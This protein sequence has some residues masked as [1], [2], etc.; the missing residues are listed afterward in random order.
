[1]SQLGS[2][3]LIQPQDLF[4]SS[5]SAQAVVGS[6][7]ETSDGRGFRYCKAGATALVPGKLYQASAEDTSN[8][9]NLAIAAA[10]TAT[11]QVVTTSTVTLAANQCA[12]GLL[13]VTTGPGAGYSYRV[14][15]HA[16]ATAAV[17]TFN[18]EDPLQVALTTSSKIDVSPNPYDSVVVNPATA[19]S[20]PVGAAICAVPASSYGWLQTHGPVALLAAGTL[21]VTQPA[22]ASA[23]TAGAVT[24][25]LQTGGTTAVVGVAVTGV[26]TTEYGQVYLTLD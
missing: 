25:F 20:A 10:G 14:A 11:F 9:E 23:A 5:T 17:V 16:A 26:S 18:L 24:S 7:A 15:S 21:S 13:V 3:N 22:A 6:Y 4:V 12:G 1:M 8:L 19:T 2:A